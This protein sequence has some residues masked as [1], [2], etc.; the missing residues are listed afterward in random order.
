MEKGDSLFN[1]LLA[2]PSLHKNGATQRLK[3][4]FLHYPYMFFLSTRGEDGNFYLEYNVEQVGK[5]MKVR[6]PDFD[7]RSWERGLKHAGFVIIQC[8][9]EPTKVWLLSASKKL[10]P[11]PLPLPS[12]IE[13]VLTHSSES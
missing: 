3:H 12:S 13:L 4:L 7:R 1:K 2:S 10:E 11:D 9:P 6:L 5:E 8:F